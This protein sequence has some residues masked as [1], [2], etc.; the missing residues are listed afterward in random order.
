MSLQQFVA[1]DAQLS[2]LLASPPVPDRGRPWLASRQRYFADLATYWLQA[3][4]RGDTRQVRLA[5]LLR[6]QLL[7]QITLRVGDHTLGSNHAELMQTCV[8]QPLPWQRQ[9]LPGAS[10]PQIFKPLLDIGSPHWRCHLPGAFVIVEG[11]V[12]GRMPDPTQPSEH[13]LLCSLSHGIEAFEDLA[14]LHVELCERLD[15]P[16]QSRTLLRHLTGTQEQERARHAERLRYEWFSEDLVTAQAQTLIDGQHA[17]LTQCWQNSATS[18][19]VDWTALEQR[20][21]QAFDL[22][23]WAGSQPA[24]QTR[25]GLL[26]ERNSP[27]WLRNASA[28]GLTHIMQ[29]LQELVIAIDHSVA[30]GIL[31]HEQ[32]VDQHS[33]R[34]WTRERLRSA[35]R[36]RHALDIDPLQVHVTV[37]LAR[38]RGPVLHPGLTTGYIPAASRPQVGDTIE[39]ESRTYRLDELAA[40][41][42]AWLDVD[43]WLT[44]RVHHLDNSP[45]DQV[46]PAQIKQLVRDLDVG[47]SYSRYLRSHL[48]NSPTAQ[49]RLE[50]YVEVSKARMLAEAAKARYAGHYLE[51]PFERGYTW[52]RSVLAH[53]RSVQRQAALGMHLSVRQWLIDGHTV[54]GVLLITHDI[55]SSTGFVVYTPDAPDRRAWREFRN[56]RHLL[57]TLRDKPALRDYVFDRMPL[58]SRQT[59]EEYLTKGRLGARTVTATITEHFIEAGYRAEVQAVLAAVDARTNT[60]LELVGEFALHALAITLDLISLALPSRALTALA[61]ARSVLS[62][63][64]MAKARDAD[65]R[66][67]MLKHLVE[68]F[69]HINDGVNSIGGST[70]LRRAIRALPPAPPLSLPAVLR[71]HTDTSKLHYRVDGIHKEGIYEQKSQYPGISLYFIKD[72]EGQTYQVAFDG[73]RWRVVDPRQPDAYTKVPVKRCADGQWVVDSPVRWFDGLPDLA[74]L[75]EHVSLPTVPVGIAQPPAGLYR[76]D[77]GLY[78]LAGGRALPLRPHLLEHHYH[79]QLDETNGAGAWATLRWQ[80]EQ[81]RIRVRQAGRSSDWL[82]LPQAY[83]VRRG[84]R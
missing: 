51:D 44:A 15:D 70:V 67:E 4:E 59:L 83:A 1:F 19:D 27:A 56:A 61:F 69:T 63:L 39:L 20:L 29:T 45:I 22:L 9:H 54:Q 17:R 24:L 57:R 58:A 23:P 84:S 2:V 46:T 62:V 43:Y 66:V 38:Q 42:V 5:A 82:A 75:F 68:A 77:L 18:P 49:W 21:Q 79:L 3:D 60:K 36:Q 34:K 41:N 32:F 64:D 12:E 47:D 30:P 6:A 40:L 13:A 28:Q 50:R 7:A 48:L 26:L 33:L 37:T 11:A 81:W 8:Q 25:Y 14:E 53:P 52:T 73:Y 31:S 74:A 16:Q 55:A 71:R 35:L 10:R 80:D 65:D 72:S 78:L 76:G